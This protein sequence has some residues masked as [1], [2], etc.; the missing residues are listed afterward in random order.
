[1]LRGQANAVPRNG[2]L[3]RPWGARAED[4]CAPC[5]RRVQRARARR[6]RPG[7]APARALLPETPWPPPRR[8]ASTKCATTP[9]SARPT[10]QSTTGSRKHRSRRRSRSSAARRSSSSGA[11]A[12]RSR[13]TPRAAIPERLIPFDIIPRVL[14]A[15]R[16]GAARARPRRSASR[17]STP[18]SP[19]STDARDRARRPDARELVLHNAG[20]RAE[21]HGLVPPRGVYAHIS[22][23][24]VVRIGPERVLRARGQLPHAVGRLL[25]ARESRGDDAAL[26]R[27]C[28]APSRSSRSRTIPRSCSRRCARWRPRM[29]AAIRRWCC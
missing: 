10:A 27:R 26:S 23:I 20:F 21:M 9:A 7:S 16:M 25:H 11:S 24:D 8:I 29:R 22:G 28:G 4:V 6:S 14:D 19:T 18:S 5:R 15:G 2:R 17:R 13:S 1:M 3:W 12:S